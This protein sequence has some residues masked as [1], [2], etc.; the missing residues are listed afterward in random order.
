MEAVGK[1]ARWKWAIAGVASFGVPGESA[2]AQSASPTL[3][4]RVDAGRAD[5]GPLS[6]SIIQL[7]EDLRVPTGFEYVYRNP[8]DESSL[9]R[10][11]GGLVAEFPRSQYDTGRGGLVPVVP[12]GTVFRIGLPGEWNWDNSGR[13]TPVRRSFNSIDRSV[14]AVGAPAPP[15]PDGSIDRSM[16]Q[17]DVYRAIRI[18]ELLRSIGPEGSEA[19]PARGL[20]R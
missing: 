10:V 9:I 1:T 2:T 19:G 3:F 18:G 12:P 7:P 14:P 11:S 17:S 20:E 16:W 5:T 4:Q 6:T 13:D 8:R 15:Q